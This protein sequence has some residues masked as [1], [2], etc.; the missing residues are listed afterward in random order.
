MNPVFE[1]IPQNFDP[2]FTN[3]YCEISEDALTYFYQND[4]DKMI[5]GLSLY[6]LPDKF[7]NPDFTIKDILDEKQV[8]RKNY[9]KVFISYSF[10]EFAL[11]P[12]SLFSES[13]KS[14]IMETLFG[15]GTDKMNLSDNL[16]DLEIHNYYS[17]PLFI[18]Y[19]IISHFPLAKFNHEISYILRNDHPEESILKIIFHQRKM[20]CILWINGKLTLA[21]TFYFVAAEDVIYHLLNILKQFDLKVDTKLLIAG[22]IDLDSALGTEISKYFNNV[23]YTTHA[24]F[25]DPNLEH[26]PAHYF[27]HLFSLAE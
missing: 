21:N 25:L 27:S 26:F 8:L 3:L 20:V 23:N 19:Y 12:Y 2:Q 9:N 24:A 13:E 16:A 7:S 22:M 4:Q 14:G 15:S 10:P 17:I 6:E 1:I 18:H 11:V 5:S